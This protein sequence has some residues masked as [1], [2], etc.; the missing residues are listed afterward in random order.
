MWCNSAY[1]VWI[2]ELRSYQLVGLHSME[3][4]QECWTMLSL[5]IAHWHFSAL[6]T[7]KHIKHKNRERIDVSAC[8]IPTS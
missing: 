7:D 2:R 6:V 1:T 4:M 5:S 3:Y 8:N